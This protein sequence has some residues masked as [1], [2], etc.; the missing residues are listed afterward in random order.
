MST[1][2]TLQTF[3]SSLGVKI[4]AVHVLFADHIPDF[5]SLVASA[6]L[7]RILNTSSTTKTTVPIETATI[8]RGFRP[9]KDNILNYAEEL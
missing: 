4:I 6:S 7:K 3:P 8:P 2:S 9:C 5:S 1:E